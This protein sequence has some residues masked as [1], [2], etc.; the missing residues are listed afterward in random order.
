V[1]IM[2][3]EL[4]EA[5]AVARRTQE[6]SRRL[7]LTGAL[8]ATTMFEGISHG[9]AGRSAE[10]DRL[11]ES[12]HLLGKGD[13]DIEA[14]SW[15]IGRATVAFLDEDRD[16]ARRA[17]EHADEVIRRNPV[18]MIDPAAGPA[19]LLKACE[20]TATWSGIDD[21]E[22]RSG[23]GSAWTRMWIESARGVLAGMTGERDPSTSCGEG[24]EAASRYPVFG[25]VATRM[26][27]EAQLRDAWGEPLRLLADLEVKARERGYQRLASACRS[28]QR[29]S[30]VRVPRR[31]SVDLMV[32]EALQTKGVTAR[33]AEVLALVG[34]RLTSPEIARRLFLSPR[35]VEKHVASLLTK[36]GAGG[37]AEL[38]ELA[39][40]AIAAEHEGG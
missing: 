21:A 36:T 34:E 29:A 32:P 28:M 17:L 27:A 6:E 14:G 13:P 10:M 16:R 31:R 2:R 37:R 1:R 26:V 30:G 11:L 40:R 4:D 3:G 12:A 38:A 20:G 33:E 25:L 15:A 5:V 19:V 18:L 39:R 23:L 24:L 35:T 9:L 8:A 22:R 7:G